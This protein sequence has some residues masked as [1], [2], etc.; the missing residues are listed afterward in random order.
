MVHSTILLQTVAELSFDIIASFV[1]SM[2][3]CV[4]LTFPLQPLARGNLAAAAAQD[5]VYPGLYTT[6]KKVKV[7]IFVA[8]IHTEHHANCLPSFICINHHRGGFF[9]FEVYGYFIFIV[10]FLNLILPPAPGTG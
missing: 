1:I 5:G 7:F 4:T 10:F 2:N 9:F 6:G 3:R 8:Y